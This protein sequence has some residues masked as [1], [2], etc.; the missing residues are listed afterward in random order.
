MS[1][2]TVQLLIWRLEELPPDAAVYIED[3]DCVVR[4]AQ[5]VEDETRLEHHDC[6][7]FDLP[8]KHLLEEGAVVICARR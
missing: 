5:S 8:D 7:G 6:A 4:L 1:R 3:H 2:M